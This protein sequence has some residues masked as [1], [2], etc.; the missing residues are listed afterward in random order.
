MWVTTLT[1]NVAMPSLGGLAE[2]RL[3]LADLL[4]KLSEE[5]RVW[6]EDRGPIRDGESR[7]GTW[8]Y[9]VFETVR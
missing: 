7:I 5:I 1:I 4:V 9:D 3:K 2:N 8:Q 6:S